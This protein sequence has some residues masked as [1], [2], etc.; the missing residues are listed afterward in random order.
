[1]DQVAREVTEARAQVE[2]RQQQIGTAKQ[3]VR[4]A[5][6][7]YDQNL[8]RIKNGQGLP[9]ETLQSVQ[10]LLQSRRELLRTLTDYNSSQFTL[11]RA[12]GWPVDQ[13]L[14]N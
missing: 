11:Q 5:N 7:S 14:A 4:L 12:M 10:A 2:L 8:I 3:L 6:D 13:P 1:M 9:I